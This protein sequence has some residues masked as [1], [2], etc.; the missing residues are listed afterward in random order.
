MATQPLAFEQDRTAVLIMDFS[1]RTVENAASDPKSVVE[2]AVQVLEAAR[3]AK[4]P[5]LHVMPR[6]SG[7][8][9][10][11]IHPEV[12]PIADEITIIKERWGAF[13]TTGL[14]ARLRQMR[15]DTLVLMGIATSGVVLTT[16]RWAFDMS[17]ETIIVQDA[18]SDP[19]PEVHRLLVEEVHPKSYLG[20]WRTAQVTNA[21]EFCAALS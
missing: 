16:A 9:P 6:G 17:Y 8:S 3:A 15:S 13:S 21:Q 1:T 20:L 12:A 10:V 4:I 2:R 5:V 18:C 14:D 7:E 11:K 19:E